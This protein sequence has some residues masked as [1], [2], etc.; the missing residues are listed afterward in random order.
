MTQESLNKDDR[1]DR[2]KGSTQVSRP[3]GSPSTGRD[4]G[5][6]GP[7]KP[8]EA[9]PARMTSLQHKDP[10]ST[11][12]SSGQGIAPDQVCAECA[13]TSNRKSK[14]TESSS[15]AVNKDPSRLAQVESTK[16]PSVPSKSPSNGHSEGSAACSQCGAPLSGE[17]AKGKKGAAPGRTS[18]NGS[19]HALPHPVSGG[20]GSSK[21]NSPLSGRNASRLSPADDGDDH[22]D[23]GE[24]HKGPEGSRP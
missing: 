10:S 19:D 18:G 9:D 14:A 6:R 21:T 24:G 1:D 11:R 5:T 3:S 2:R 20:S 13:G 23:D 7:W 16:Q 4:N 17:S 8:T 15:P 12:T 22:Q